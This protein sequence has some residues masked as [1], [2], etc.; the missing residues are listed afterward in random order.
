V[1]QSVSTGKQANLIITS[2]KNN[3]YA[4]GVAACCPIRWIVT[5]P[6]CWLTGFAACIRIAVR[7][8]SLTYFARQRYGSS[9]PSRPA[10]RFSTVIS[11]IRS[12]VRLEALPRCGVMTRLSSASSLWSRGSGSGAV[13]SMAAAAMRRLASAS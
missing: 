3:R 8:E 7:R 5:K 6:D 1:C 11:T 4:R 2:I 9:R 12:R 13:T 10:S